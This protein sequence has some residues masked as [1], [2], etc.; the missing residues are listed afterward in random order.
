MLTNA[1]ESS[2]RPFQ[3]HLMGIGD[4]WEMTLEYLRHFRQCQRALETF[5]DMPQ[6]KE[7]GEISGYIY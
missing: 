5:R 1:P 6:I 3:Q 2:W 7:P 4:I